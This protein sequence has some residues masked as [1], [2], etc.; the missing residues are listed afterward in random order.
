MMMMR[1]ILLLLPFVLLCMAAVFK[2]IKGNPT[3]DDFKKKHIIG[4][5]DL[6]G[7]TYNKK[8]TDEIKKREIFINRNNQQE[9]KPINTFI[10]GDEQSIKDIC[11]S[12]YNYTVNKNNQMKTFTC[13]SEKFDIILCKTQ[14]IGKLFKNG[15]NYEG[16]FHEKM[17]VAVACENGLPVHY[18]IQIDECD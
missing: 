1:N 17:H 14:D 11:K 15:C 10:Y 8:C 4:N 6:P 18:E 13:S 16:T 5:N 12:K 3:Y 7:N 9:C 2:E